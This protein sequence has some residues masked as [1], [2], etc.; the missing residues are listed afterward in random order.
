M[1]IRTNQLRFK[2]HVRLNVLNKPTSCKKMRSAYTPNKTQRNALI[3]HQIDYIISNVRHVFNQD[4]IPKIISI[5]HTV[6]SLTEC[7]V[8]VLV[9]K[10][11]DVRLSFRLYVCQCVCV[12]VCVSVC[13]RQN[14]KTPWLISMK[15]TMKGSLYVQLC[16]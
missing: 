14:A 16:V 10:Y 5:F 2:C 3:S 15:L 7:I 6:I 12:Y 4:D 11:R 8:I 9:G 1:N 13:L